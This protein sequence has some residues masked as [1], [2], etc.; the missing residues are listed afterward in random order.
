[1]AIILRSSAPNSAVEVFRNLIRYI[2]K[3]EI[4]PLVSKTYQ[5]EKIK[6]AQE[7]F[8]AKKHVG[9]LVLIPPLKD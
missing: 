8:L 5:L 1:M 4:K 9:K 7:E 3:S 2:E 6:Q